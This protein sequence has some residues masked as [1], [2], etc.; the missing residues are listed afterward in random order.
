MQQLFLSYSG[1]KYRAII[2][3]TTP[4]MIGIALKLEQFSDPITSKRFLLSL[5]A[6][7]SAL[8]RLN[9][10]I[11][12]GRPYQAEQSHY[13]DELANA[14]ARGKIHFVKA[15]ELP[16][17]TAE[18]RHNNGS[19]KESVKIVA[20]GTLLDNPSKKIKHFKNEQDV[21]EYIEALQP[22]EKQLKAIAEHL[23]LTPTSNRDQ[24]IKGI[25]KK[26]SSGEAAVVIE[27][28]SDKTSASDPLEFIADGFPGNRIAGLGPEQEQE[29]EPEVC[30]ICIASS[31]NV[32]CD[33]GRKSGPTN[34]IQVVPSPTSS[35]TRDISVMGY[36]V[37]SK[38]EYGGKDKVTGKLSLSNNKFSSCFIT[39]NT[40]GAWIGGPEATLIASGNTEKEPDI[41]PINASPS[42]KTIKGKGCSGSTKSVT[43][44][45]FPNHYHTIEGQLDI[46]KDWV[47]KFNDSWEKWGKKFFDLSP[48]SLTPKITGPTGSFSAAWG[49][50][51][52]DDWRAYYDVN[53]SFG[54]NPI[55]GVE[56]EISV[57]LVKVGLAAAGIPP[58]LSDLGTKH[59][60]DILVFGS[61]G[62]KGMLTGSPHAKFFSDGTKEYD[63]QAKFTVEGLVKIGL[64]GRLGSDYIVSATLILHGETK[65]IGEDVI[66][67]NTTGVFAQTTVNIEPF[68]AVAKAEVRYLVIFSKTKERKW[69][70]WKQHQLYQSDKEKIFP[71]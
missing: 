44:E 47:K 70:P 7:S 32:S 30:G 33:H 66:D 65:V 5:N 27:T 3:G 1:I 56:I 63:G 10:E 57:S 21:S 61:A 13:L 17:Q 40:K 36:K 23:E 52:N 26:I 58:T 51:E 54:L 60:A 29:E 8:L 11:N 25:G 37:E 64:R 28:K 50:K 31:F 53:A 24:T 55:L 59:L 68:T 45:T 35:R 39:T 16:S 4:T 38:L 9:Y 69:S 43:V 49:W 46:F 20:S 18:L 19:T 6:S 67:V 62:C 14:L 41:W 12:G 34:R 22:E 2:P 71:R 15:G 42:I 48:V